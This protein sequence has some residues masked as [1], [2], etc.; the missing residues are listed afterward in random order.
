MADSQE[1]TINST[2]SMSMV[3][4]CAK[5]VEMEMWP[6]FRYLFKQINNF[7][8]QTY[9]GP[10]DEDNFV[11]IWFALRSLSIDNFM[12]K[13]QNCTN[14]DDFLNYMSLISD[15]VD[16]P[17]RLWI[18]M[19]TE[20]QTIFRATPSQCRYIAKTFFTPA[21]LFE[22]SIDAFL[23]SELC[24]LAIV[25]TEDDVIDRFYALAGLVR[26]IGISKNDAIPQSYSNY[27]SRLLKAFI[28]LPSFSAKR[29]VWLVEAIGTNL[30]INPN[31]LRGY[32]SESITEFI[33]KD[34]PPMQKLEMAGT[35]SSSPFMCHIPILKSLVEESYETVV[36]SMYQNFTKYILPGF[37]DLKWNGDA[38]GLPS[39]PVRCW[40]LYFDSLYINNQDSPIIKHAIEKS[41]CQSLQFFA[42]YYGGI[43]PEL[44]RA[45]DMRRD[46]FCIIK[47]VNNLSFK[48]S[49]DDYK[50]VWMLM[51][52]AAI[53]GAELTL[54]CNIPPGESSKN[55][56]LLG[57]EISE[58]GYDFLNYRTALAVLIEKFSSEKD[59]IPEMIKFLRQNYH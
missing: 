3:E 8:K 44:S 5:C 23:D 32:C 34:F 59:A 52:I 9:K 35:F 4:E 54:I 31:T 37:A 56:V 39:D 57:L 58:D 27:I 38:Y 2:N 50:H 47:Y 53:I 51:L 46:I 14:F 13:I 55:T 26:S 48:L 40:K 45:S 1:V 6:Q 22:Y 11:R 20:L 21:Q 24:N 29:F 49:D 28:N 18:I 30:F 19:H 41:I 15:M 42:D 25:K 33:K 12:K 16:D 43:Q 17:K 10:A 7:Y 36:T